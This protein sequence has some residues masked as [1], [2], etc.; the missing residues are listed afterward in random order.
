[1]G[2]KLSI[3]PCY[4]HLMNTFTR[5]P[6]SK[7]LH[8]TKHQLIALHKLSLKTVGDL[9]YHFPVRYGD[10]FS[11]TY[12][13][14]AVPDTSVTL[15]GRIDHLEA[16]QTFKTKKPMVTAILSDQSGKIKITWFNQIFMSKIFKDGD[17]V[18]VSGIIKNLGDRVTMQNPNM[19]K[20]TTMPLATGTNL[21][22]EQKEALYL[23]IYRESKGISSLS[24]HHMMKKIISNPDFK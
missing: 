20:T 23:P 2:L 7:I 21:F 3:T 5:L 15:Y 12:I 18:K 14:D 8:L 22:G 13:K 11:A 6:L 10:N 24:I 17:M 16:G 9:L 4:T 1:M 19:E